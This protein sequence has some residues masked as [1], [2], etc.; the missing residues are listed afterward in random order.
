MGPCGFESV[1]HPMLST[2]SKD[3]VHV[4]DV[5]KM[6]TNLPSHEIVEKLRK[7]SDIAVNMALLQVGALKLVCTSFDARS[8][9]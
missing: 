7:S 6:A 2:D 4:D 5:I 1:Q 3:D 9:F 8:I